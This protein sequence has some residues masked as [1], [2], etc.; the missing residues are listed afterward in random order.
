MLT[1]HVL[2]APT[3]PTLVV[4]QHRRHRTEMLA[5]LEEQSARLRLDPPEVVVALS[6]RWISEG[7]F[8]VDTGAHH[9]TI[10]DYPGFG[11]EVRYDCRGHA[12]LA[13]AL[14]AA[15]TAAGVRVAAATRGVDSGVTV[16]LHFLFPASRPPVVPLSLADRSAEECRAW[17]A[18]L[19]AT[20]AARRERVIFV[21]GGILSDN[22]HAWSLGRELPETRRFDEQ[23]LEALRQ[24]AW[25][26]LPVLDR[27]GAEQVMP[28]AG[29][30][31]LEVLRGF[32]AHD[33]TAV[34]RCYQSSPG[35]GA[36]LVEFELG[37]RVAGRPPDAAGA[38]PG[39][40][41]P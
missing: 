17:G 11:V 12:D 26:A 30:R 6:A 33:A 24:G 27:A 2:L 34:I 1:P 8:L 13:R 20:L 25:D 22:Q 35:V 7:P 4:D 18:T 10:T 38:R 36:A 39:G 19:R 15:G 14:V 31:H 3:L 32:L 29:L 21:V 16:P 9:H 37:D 23:V 28:Q 5:A 40:G 41:R